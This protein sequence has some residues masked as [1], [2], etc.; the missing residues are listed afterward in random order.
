M[1]FDHDKTLITAR[2]HA[3]TSDSFMHMKGRIEM[4]Q[5]AGQGSDRPQV[6]LNNCYDYDY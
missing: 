2:M 6:S 3:L 5:N 4:E 1:T